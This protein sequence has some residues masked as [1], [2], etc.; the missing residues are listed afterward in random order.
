MKAKK[1]HPKIYYRR[2]RFV[3]CREL[4]ALNKEMRSR[5]EAHIKRC[6]KCQASALSRQVSRS[7][8]V[9]VYGDDGDCC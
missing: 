1:S 7:L 2:R 4:V 6:K 3:P 8:E 5:V 9:A